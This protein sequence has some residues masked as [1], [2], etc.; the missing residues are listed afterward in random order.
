MWFISLSPD[1]FLMFF[2]SVIHL[3]NAQD[4]IEKLQKVCLWNHK[5]IV[6]VLIIFSLF[7]IFLLNSRYVSLDLKLSSQANLCEV[8]YWTEVQRCV[9]SS[10]LK[11]AFR[12]ISF[13]G[14]KITRIP[15]DS[16][17]IVSRIHNAIR[18]NDS[19]KM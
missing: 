11:R 6:I 15:E 7:P 4:F 5:G 13:N 8:S 12:S 2:S 9:T 17:L 18:R 1:F 10:G 16:T 3:N 14:E 19:L